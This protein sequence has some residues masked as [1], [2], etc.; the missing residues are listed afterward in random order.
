MMNAEYADVK[1]AE[2]T[3]CYDRQDSDDYEPEEEGEE[4]TCPMCGSN[5]A[6]WAGRLGNL[7]HANC[8]NCGYTS[9]REIQ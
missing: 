9:Y 1:E 7:I 8:R 2:L 6:A 5:V 3:G 4:F